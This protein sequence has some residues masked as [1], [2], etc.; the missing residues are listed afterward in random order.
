M[1]IVIAFV[2]GVF[3]GGFGGFQWGASV[4]RKAQALL[5]GA[6]K[7]IGSFSSKM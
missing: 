3:L 7:S 2:V 5:S 1:H 6:S 4:E